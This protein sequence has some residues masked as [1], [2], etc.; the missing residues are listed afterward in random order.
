[1]AP[2][3]RRSDQNAIEFHI[4]VVELGRSLLSRISLR[5]W[6]PCFALLAE[7]N[8]PITKIG[9]E[10]T[11]DL[12]CGLHDFTSSVEVAA[13]R[14]PAA[15]TSDDTC[16]GFLDGPGQQLRRNRHVQSCSKEREA[17]YDRTHL[18]VRLRSDSENFLP[19]KERLPVPEKFRLNLVRAEVDQM[20]LPLPTD[21]AMLALH[22]I[23]Q[24]P[25]LEVDLLRRDRLERGAWSDRGWNINKPLARAFLQAPANEL[26]QRFL[27]GGKHEQ[28][29]MCRLP[30]TTGGGRAR[31][32]GAA[33]ELID[34]LLRQ[35]PIGKRDLVEGQSQIGPGEGKGVKAGLRTGPGDAEGI[36]SRLKRP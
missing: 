10:L 25:A 2:P 31:A 18:R 13:L 19:R 32:F 16:V 17:I 3:C 12:T 9:R 8:E 27:A 5:D 36:V 22:G 15:H 20:T 34:D 28:G 7:V 1:M 21:R 23:K 29:G 24:A 14:H 33:C 26:R 30:Q 4:P 11:L 35:A 6:R